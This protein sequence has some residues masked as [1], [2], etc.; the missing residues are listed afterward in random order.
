M[1]IPSPNGRPRALTPEQER[2]VYL[3]ITE[4]RRGRRCF[5]FSRLAGELG[6]GVSTLERVVTRWRR[7]RLAEIVARFHEEPQNPPEIVNP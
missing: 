1:M 7:R 6:V 5:A 3:E 2:H 4:T